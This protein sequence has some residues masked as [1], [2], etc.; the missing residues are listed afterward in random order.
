MKFYLFLFF[1][2]TIIFYIAGAVSGASLL[3]KEWDLTTRQV[4][5]SF[6]VACVIIITFIAYYIRSENK[7]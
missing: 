3:I 2:I 4:T 5:A 6:W 7:E 1:V